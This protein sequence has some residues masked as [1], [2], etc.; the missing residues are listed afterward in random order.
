MRRVIVL[1]KLNELHSVRR[2][3]PPWEVDILRRIH[4]DNDVKLEGET[5]CNLRVPD[6]GSEWDRLS[7]RFG[8]DRETKVP[9]VQTVFGSPDHLAALMAKD[10]A[11]QAEFD[12]ADEER[13]ELEASNQA[14][15]QA[16]GTDGKPAAGKSTESKKAGAAK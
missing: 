13:A 16:T 4:G 7:L 3:V 5:R 6:P 12:R 2:E 8:S 14:T 11:E 1:V 9:H 10:L 15:N